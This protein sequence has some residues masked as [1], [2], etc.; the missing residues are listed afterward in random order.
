MLEWYISERARVIA[1]G[2]DGM[3]H[4]FGMGERP[5]TCDTLVFIDVRRAAA[6]QTLDARHSNR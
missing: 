5:A 3:W 2:G 6:A 1:Q 4:T